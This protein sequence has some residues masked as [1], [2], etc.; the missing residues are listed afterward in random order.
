M[1][2]DVTDMVF[3][4]RSNGILRKVKAETTWVEVLKVTFFLFILQTFQHGR[5][6]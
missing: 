2:S 4:A 1:T 3:S 5:R 6:Q